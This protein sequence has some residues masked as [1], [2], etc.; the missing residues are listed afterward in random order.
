LIAEA[1]KKGSQLVLFPEVFVGGFP[2]GSTFGA[3][4][5]TGGPGLAKG[6][7]DYRKYFASAID[8]PGTTSYQATFPLENTMIAIFSKLIS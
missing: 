7:E 6:K 1:A 4:I 3:V 8:V 5:G 2:R